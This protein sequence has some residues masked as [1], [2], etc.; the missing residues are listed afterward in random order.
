MKEYLSHRR[1]TSSVIL[2][3]KVVGREKIVAC[4]LAGHSKDYAVRVQCSRVGS[5]PARPGAADLGEGELYPYGGRVET[6][7]ASP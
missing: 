3:L 7:P 1:K 6:N 2:L 5:G 4:S